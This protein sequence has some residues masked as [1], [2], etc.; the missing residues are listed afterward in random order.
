MATKP[1][2]RDVRILEDAKELARAAAEHIATTARAAIAKRNRFTIALAGCQ[3]PREVYHLL[4][5]ELADRVPWGRVELFF[6]DERCVPPDNPASNYG[7][8]SATMLSRLRLAKRRVHRIVGEVPRDDAVRS[9]ER[10]LRRAFGPAAE[11]SFDLALLGV[12]ADGHTASIFPGSAAADEREKWVMA[13]DAPADQSP[14][15]RIT[16]TFAVLDKAREVCMMVAGAGKR[17]VV[18][19]ILGDAPEARDLPAARAR[20]TSR[21]LWLMDRAAA[22]A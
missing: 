13:V 10:D 11:S 17:K 1:V 19:A 18:S 6:G 8:V 5:T 14:R 7:L 15:E 9:Y 16:L 2:V 20:G 3:T 12:G 21:T 22:P 4:A